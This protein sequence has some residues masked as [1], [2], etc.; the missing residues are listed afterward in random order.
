L[1]PFVTNDKIP[2]ML[3][4]SS[5]ISQVVPMTAPET[6][7]FFAAGQER[8]YESTSNVPLRSFLQVVSLHPGDLPLADTVTVLVPNSLPMSASLIMT[9]TTLCNFYAINQDLILAFTHYRAPSQEESTVHENNATRSITTISTIQDL[10]VTVPSDKQEQLARAHFNSLAMTQGQLHSRYSLDMQVKDVRIATTLHKWNSLDRVEKMCSTHGI[11]GVDDDDSCQN[12]DSWNQCFD[13]V[14]QG[15]KQLQTT[16]C[17]YVFT[18]NNKTTKK[19][20]RP[21]IM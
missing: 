3:L 1:S 19:K 4:L 14:I 2:E 13:L 9:P 17:P 16:G 10:S 5:W 15:C 12:Q 7:A 11:P 21:R 20:N 6:L 18:V 8:L